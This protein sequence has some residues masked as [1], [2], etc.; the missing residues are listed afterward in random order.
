MGTGTEAASEGLVGRMEPSIQM[1]Y[2]GLDGL[3]TME[4]SAIS[5]EVEAMR[6]A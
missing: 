5:H 4:D 1:S 6:A 2:A 3:L